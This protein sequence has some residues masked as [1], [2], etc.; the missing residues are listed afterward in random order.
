MQNKSFTRKRPSK[1]GNLI[2]SMYVQDDD[3][4][5]VFNFPVR[6]CCACSDLKISSFN[7]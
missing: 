6:E 2:Y 5:C 4:K 1:N 3:G 7:A